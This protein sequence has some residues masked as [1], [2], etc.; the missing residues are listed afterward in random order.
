[1]ASYLRPR[2][3]RKSTAISQNIVLKRGEIFMEV[4]ET[5]VGTG[6]GKI[7]IGDGT[8][9]YSNLP[10]FINADAAS[11]DVASEAINYSESS[12]DEAAKTDISSGKPLKTIIAGL[13]KLVLSAKSSAESVEM[14]WL[15]ATYMADE[16]ALYWSSANY[17]FIKPNS[18]FKVY[19]TKFGI[20]PQNMEVVSD[21]MNNSIFKLYF[22][23]KEAFQVL[24]C[25]QNPIS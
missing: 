21:A 23:E 15:S 11:V 3:G 1:M 6:L 8:T 25:V 4:P 22:K 17:S 24:V 10:Y 14:N 20:M 16:Q 2:R 12:S 13:K 5:G 19:T 7:K 18:V 9:S